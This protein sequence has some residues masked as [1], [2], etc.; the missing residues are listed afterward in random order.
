MKQKMLSHLLCGVLLMSF[1]LGSHNGRL[2]LWKDEDP[3]P[4]K[5]FPCPIAVLP[6]A[7]Q[8]QLRKGVR[9]ETMEDVNRLL[10]IFLS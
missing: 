2:A 9:L 10:E 4:C 1:L 3:E 8:D 5:V 6:K 7:V